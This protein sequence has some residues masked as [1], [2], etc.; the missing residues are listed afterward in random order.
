[1]TQRP[2]T[3]LKRH[4]TALIRRRLGL[5]LMLAGTVAAAIIA[6]TADLIPAGWTLG[7]S[8]QTC[9]VERVSDG[10][11]LQLR[12]GFKPV[13]VRLYCIDAPEMGQSPWGERSRAHLSSITPREVKLVKIDHDRYGRIVGEVYTVEAS[14]R[15]L[16][17]EQVKAGQAAVYDQYCDNPRYASA[18]REAKRAKCGIWSRPGEQQTP[19]RYRQRER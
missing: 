5:P 8:G 12:C 2:Q 11:T 18:E 17:L 10:D 16:N 9:R 15:L 4:L 6:W 19:W 13:K 1:M 14:P 7:A 3:L